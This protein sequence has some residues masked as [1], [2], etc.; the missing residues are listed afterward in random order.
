[1]KV[2]FV[3]K[4]NFSESKYSNFCTKKCIFFF[5][6]NAYISDFYSNEDNNVSEYW[7]WLWRVKCYLDHTQ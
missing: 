1:M 3:E 5:T 6:E 7:L 4:K 2:R